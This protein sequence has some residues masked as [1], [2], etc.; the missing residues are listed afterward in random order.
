MRPAPSRAVAG[1]PGAAFLAGGTNLVDHMK[2][3]V[4]AP[5]LLVDV[6]RLPLDRVEAT[7]RRRTAHRRR[8]C[9]TATSPPHRDRPRALPACSP[10]AAGRRLRPAAQPRHHRRQ[11]AAAHPLRATSRTSTTP[12]NK[13]EPGSGCSALGG[14]TR[15][16]R[17]PRRLRAL[18]RGAPVGHG[19]GDGRRS[20]PWCSVHRPRRRAGRS[21][22]PS[23]TACPA[24]TRARHH[25]GPRRAGHGGRARRRRSAPARATARC[26]TAPRT[27]S[28]WS[29][30]RPRSTCDDG[31]VARRA[32]R[33]RRRGPQAVA[34][35]RAEEALRGGRGD[36]R[37]RSAAPPRPSW[38]AADPLRGQRLQ[39]A[40]GPQRRRRGAPDLAGRRRVTA[41]SSAAAIGVTVRARSTARP[42]SPGTAPYATSTRSTTPLHCTRSRRR[43]PAAGS[44]RI[45]T[46][47]AEA[48]PG[49]LARAH[50]PQR[51]R[52]GDDRDAEL[53]VLQSA[54]VAFRGQ[55]VAAVVAETPEAARHAAEL[56][57]R[58]TTTRRPHDVELLGRTATTCTRPEQVNPATRPTPTRATSTPRW[59]RGRASVDQTYTTAWYHNNPM[60]PHTDHRRSGEADRLTLYDS[61]QG[62][63]S[64]RSTIAAVFGLEP[65]A[66]AGDRALRRRRVRLEG[67]ARTRTSCSP[68]WPPAL[69]RAG[70][71]KLALT[72]QQMFSL[73]G[74]RTPTIQRVRLGADADG[75]LTAISPRGRRADLAHQGV[76]RADGRRHPHDVRRRRTGAPPTG[77]PRSTCRCRRGCARRASARACSRS[78]VALDELAEALRRR[79]GRAADPQRRPDRPGDRPA[80]V[81]PPP[82]GVPA[83]RAPQVRLG[84]ARRRTRARG[85][86]AA[87]WSARRGQRRP[88]RRARCPDRAARDP[89]RRR[90]PLRVADRRRRHRHRH[91]DGA[92]PDRRRRPGRRRRRVVTGDRRH[93]AAGGDRGRRLVGHRP[94]GARGR[95]RRPGAARG[96]RPRPAAR[97]RGR[98]PR[99]RPTPTRSA[100]RCTPS[101]R[102]SPRSASTPTP[103][104]SGCRACS[105]CSPSGGS[106]TRG[107][108]ARS[109]LGG[110]TMGLSMA[111]HEDERARPPH[112]PRRQPRPRRAT[113]SPPTP[114]CRDIDVDWLDEP[115]P[116]A[117][118]MGS[119]A[120]ARSAS[121]A[122]PA[123]IAN[124]V[125][126]ATG[127]RVRDLPITPGQVLAV[128]GLG[129]AP[130]GIRTQNL[131]IKSPLLCH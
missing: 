21:P 103:A 70:P 110:M 99:R 126:D 93:R 19:R 39:G 25:A 31:T 60:E 5:D 42:R 10:G 17:D 22:W 104:R 98:R 27:P 97:R 34:R 45:D 43:S 67:A 24:T 46:R 8:R 51:A 23:C 119:R 85:A 106:S 58:A 59:R 11:P 53:A 47:G 1:R 12:C 50:P 36:R 9:A 112:G 55:F 66:G 88:T 71:V 123:A 102:S 2:L 89:R 86:T 30:S 101:A 125:Y 87:G 78:E 48:R 109:S 49:V 33:A 121:S 127:I 68:P 32:H 128:I 57:E 28:R 37:T 75:R 62:V 108:P 64:V 29:R 79:P 73:V 92:H 14:L 94:R 54:E 76:R 69:R 105:G 115:D 124:A 84:P 107:R 40:D 120:S 6:S 130:P 129:S 82:G 83:P 77:W 7:R 91:V 74:Y 15:A 13:R 4:A 3:G 41:P 117:N 100:A 118:P 96:A 111:L 65:D 72:R 35:R 80:V 44:S 81:Q 38:R 63:H 56:V 18:R 90:R 61:T 20:T 16:P 113:T 114:T 26:A 131:R 116:H 52:P 122:P 95:R